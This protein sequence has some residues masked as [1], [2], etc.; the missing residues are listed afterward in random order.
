VDINTFEGS[1]GKKLTV[2]TLADFWIDGS[3]NSHTSIATIRGQNI[4]MTGL[5]IGTGIN[6]SLPKTA[7]SAST[8][9][10]PSDSGKPI[11]E[12]STGTMGLDAKTTKLANLAGDTVD[13]AVDRVRQILLAKGLSELP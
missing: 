6:W 13:G 1:L 8:F 7:K 5:T 9:V 10:Y 12:E 2:W 4:V 11:V 3:T